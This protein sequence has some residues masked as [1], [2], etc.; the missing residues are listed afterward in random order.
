MSEYLSNQLAECLCKNGL[1][2]ANETNDYRYYTQL[3]LEKLIGFS[4]ILLVALSNHLL[5]QTIFFLLFFSN[6]GFISNADEREAI[7]TQKRQSEIAKAITD[8]VMEYLKTR[9]K[10]KE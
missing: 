2:T 4:L 5:L 6:D 10:E 3:F 7:I 8:G 1:I 9:G